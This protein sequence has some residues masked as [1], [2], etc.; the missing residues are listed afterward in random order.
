MPSCVTYSFSL[1]TRQKKVSMP[2]HIW[3]KD[4]A[5]I[6]PVDYWFVAVPYVFLPFSKPASRIAVT[7][8]SICKNFV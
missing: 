7:N 5:D 2:I 8:S 6:D 1:S 4:T 3:R